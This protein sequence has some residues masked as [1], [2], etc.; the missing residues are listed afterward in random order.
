MEGPGSTLPLS[1]SP[2]AKS[3]EPTASEKKSERQSALELGSVNSLIV[4]AATR[5][6]IKYLL[7][8]PPRLW[9]FVMPSQV[10]RTNTSV[11][12]VLH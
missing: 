5:T 2:H 7:F 10:D 4:D 12:R 6:V 3:H 1:P 9:H 8:K 11:M